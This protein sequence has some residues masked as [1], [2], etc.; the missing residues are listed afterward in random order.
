VNIRFS[1]TSTHP[2]YGF[3][4]TGLESIVNVNSLDIDGD[5]ISDALTDGLLI[6]RRMFALS[7]EALTQ[8]ALSPNAEY[9]EAEDI[10][11]RIDNLG[12]LLDIDGNGQ[13]DALSD[14]L[15]ILRYLFQLRGS[16]LIDGVV[17]PD[18]TR[19]TAAEIEA[20]LAKM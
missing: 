1:A 15:L 9:T 20:Y 7:E 3:S 2:G 5:G 19:K 14:G 16:A 11:L 12:V 4:G 18:A 8:Q 17:K 13:T 6:L 10:A